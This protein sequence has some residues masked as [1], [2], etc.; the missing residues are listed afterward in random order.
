M[1]KD[2]TFAAFLRDVNGCLSSPTARQCFSRF[3]DAG[4]ELEPWDEVV[5]CFTRG[6]MVDAYENGVQFETADY[7]CDVQRIEG[8]WKLVFFALK[9]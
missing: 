2:A 6:T 8:R 9:P 7:L 4:A 5:A 3:A 1:R